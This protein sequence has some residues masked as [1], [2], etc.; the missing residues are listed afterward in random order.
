MD[1]QVKRDGPA[2]WLLE[3]VVV[4]A[5]PAVGWCLLVAGRALLVPA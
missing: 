2:V 5:S 1:N 3:A 4:L